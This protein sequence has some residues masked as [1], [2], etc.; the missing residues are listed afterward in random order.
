MGDLKFSGFGGP[1]K[2]FA[3]DEVI[4]ALSMSAE[5]RKNPAH[6]SMLQDIS[7]AMAGLRKYIV[8]N[9][10]PPGRGKAISIGLTN[11]SKSLSA[12]I[13]HE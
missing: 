7:D 6:T 13:S 8:N 11:K 2:A 10:Y 5:Y 1:A 12:R 3:S 9:C 4:D